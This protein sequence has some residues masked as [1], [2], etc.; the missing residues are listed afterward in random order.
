M[1]CVEGVQH[2]AR[3]VRG[4]AADLADR[5]VGDVLGGRDGVRQRG[6][7]QDRLSRAEGPPLKQDLLE[8]SQR[9]FGRGTVLDL[10]E[11]GGQPGLPL[12]GG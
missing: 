6:Q 10:R 9:P 1:E 12:L 2:A 5:G 11:Q 7:E 8:A 3:G 4:H